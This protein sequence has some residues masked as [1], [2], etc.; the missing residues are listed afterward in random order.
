M[1]FRI[2]YNTSEIVTK[3]NIAFVSY[4]QTLIREAEEKEVSSKQ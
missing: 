1:Y 3:S 2:I 4:F